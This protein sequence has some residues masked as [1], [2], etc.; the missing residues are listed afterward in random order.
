MMLFFA[1]FSVTLFQFGYAAGVD[2]QVENPLLSPFDKATCSSNTKTCPNSCDNAN[3]GSTCCFCD[4]T[5]NYQMTICSC[6]PKNTTC[7]PPNENTKTQGSLCCPVGST[8][9]KDG[10]CQIIK[11]DVAVYAKPV[12]APTCAKDAFIWI[13]CDNYFH[14]YFDGKPQA[15]NFASDWTQVDKMKILPETK[16]ITLAGENYEFEAGFLVEFK[17]AFFDTTAPWMCTNVRPD[18]DQWMKADFEPKDGW[19]T[20]V[21]SEKNGKK[22]ETWQRDPVKDMDP[23]SRWFWSNFS[24]VTRDAK[25]NA[26]PWDKYCYCRFVIK[27][28]S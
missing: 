21:L 7:C 25:S 12:C 17:N 23:E 2:N 27:V 3:D 13:T 10:K 18:S 4:D 26:A 8:C 20:A 22:V 15:L 5:K 19:S 9:L 14:L 6:C 24:P 28:K 1:F 11:E 16:V